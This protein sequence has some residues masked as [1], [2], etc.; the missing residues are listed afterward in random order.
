[1]A[2]EKWIAVDFDGTLTSYGDHWPEI[3]PENPYAFDVLKRCKREGHHIILYTC[4]QGKYLEAAIE[5]MTARGVIPDAV[6]RNPY[7]ESLYGTPG[8]KMFADIYID[9]RSLGIRKKNGSVDFKY[10]KRN[11]RKIFNV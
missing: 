3:G 6:N 5:W 8:Q 2:K 9:D 10:I 1:M 11:Y 4:R 7:A